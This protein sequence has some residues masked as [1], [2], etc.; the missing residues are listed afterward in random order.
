MPTIAAID[1]MRVLAAT[2]ATLAIVG[3]GDN[4]PAIQARA[5]AVNARVGRN[6][7]R[8]VGTMADPRAAYGAADI[9]LGMGGSAARSLAFGK[10][11]VAQGEAG[12]S[13][14]FEPGSAATLARSSYWSAEPVA[15]PAARLVA[16]IAPLLADAGRRAELGSFGRAFAEQRF[17]LAAMAERLDEFYRTARAEY[18]TRAWLADL[19][20]EARMLSAKIAR[21]ARV[22]LRATPAAEDTEAAP[23]A[24]ASTTASAPAA[25]ER[26]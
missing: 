7:V 13:A 10:P 25:E 16:I 1:A 5:D 18:T 9:M 8:L 3:T 20:I 26:A 22:T 23:A 12:W 17:G 11:L 21:A 2:G 6:A 14:L 4:V 19:P 24:P 15:D